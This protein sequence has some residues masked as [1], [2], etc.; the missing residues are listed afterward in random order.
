[1]GGAV[2][3]PAPGEDVLV[4][5]GGAVLF[6]EGGCEFVG[7]GVGEGGAGGGDEFGYL[8]VGGGVGSAV[9]E[10]VQQGGEEESLLLAG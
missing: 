10:Q 1:M 9:L 6:E 3:H 5:C 2:E 7:D 4:E 8:F